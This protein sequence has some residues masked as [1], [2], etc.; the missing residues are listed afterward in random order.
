MRAARLARAIAALGLCLPALA[1]CSSWMGEADDPPLPGERVAVLLYDS[2]LEPDSRIAGRA[3]ELPPPYRNANWSQA[4]GGP[5]HALGH[6]EGPTVLK[7]PA[8]RVDIGAGAGRYRP[9][10]SAP[11]IAGGR[12]YAMDSKFTIS[13]YGADRGKRLWRTALEPPGRDEEAFG[14][15]LAYDGGRVYAATGYSEVAA[16]DAESGEIV[17]RQ[18]VAAPV[19]G[20]PLVMEGRVFVV[21]LDNNLIALSAATGDREWRHAGFAETAALLGGASPAGVDGTVIAPY[22]SGEV[23]AIRAAN[24][25]PTWA[26]NLAAARRLDATSAL[27]DI[28]A[29]PVTDGSQVYAVSHSGRIVAIDMRSGV[30]AWDRNIGGV[31]TPWVAGDWLFLVTNEAELVALTRREG[32]V[33]WVA[34]LDRYRDPDDRSDPIHWVGPLLVSG[35]LLLFGDHGEALVFDP[36]D[37][38]SV[39]AYD[40]R[41]GVIAAAVAD[42][43]LYLQTRD[44]DLIAYR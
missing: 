24:G 15:G 6:V 43:T 23:Y 25:R 21:T 30:R 31:E 42:G 16:L 13:A 4:A 9:L 1:G 19:R 34:A 33:R 29:H 32:R 8:W 20:A 39:A 10:L 3:V 17:W 40:I 22:S 41:G 11:V 12:V 28:R 36:A 26:E 35:R 2:E 5:L 38:R 18:P 7:K 44:A 14:G 37:G 27:A